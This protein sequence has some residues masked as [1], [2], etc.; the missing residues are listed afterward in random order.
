VEIKRSSDSRIRREVVGQM[1]DY[2]AN[3]QKYWPSDIIKELAIRKF[4]DEETLNVK[5]F[6]FLRL[7]DSTDATQDIYIYWNT[8][9]E[10]LRNGQVRLLFVADAIPSELRRI[11]EFLNEHMPRVEVLGVE[12]RQY[13]RKGTQALVPRVIGQSEFARQQKKPY[14][15]SIEKTSMKEFLDSCPEYTR[16]FFNRVFTESSNRGF[17][18][19]WGTVG[20][21]IRASLPNGKMATYFYEYPPS[22][23]LSQVPFFQAYLRSIEDPQIPDKALNAFLKHI[24]FVQKESSQQTLEIKLDEKGLWQADSGLSEV[25]NIAKR[26]VDGESLGSN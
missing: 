24:P 18:T 11:I 10:N 17:T 4:G 15:G 12:I 1:L 26:I 9:K 25:M 3:T 8:V 20:F 6:E 14:R 19:A 16:D 5:L 2:A 21:S 7:D 22:V 13:K 23:N